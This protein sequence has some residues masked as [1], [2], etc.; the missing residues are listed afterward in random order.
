MPGIDAGPDAGFT[1]ERF[2][3]ELASSLAGL[4]VSVDLTGGSDTRLVAAL[5]ARSLPFECAVSG[6]ADSSDVE[7]AGE[8]ARALGRPLHV[9]IHDASDVGDVAAIC[10]RPPT[11]S[12][13]C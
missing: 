6:T 1:V 12:P 3:Q 7:I 4:N 9:T 8:V 10:S 2:F 5:L 13:T 11:A